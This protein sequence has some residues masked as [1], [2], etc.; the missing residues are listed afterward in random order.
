[1]NKED[2]DL[3]FA[4]NINFVRAADEAVRR[5]EKGLPSDRW[6]DGHAGQVRAV[7]GIKVYRRM[8]ELFAE[9]WTA[10]DEMDRQRGLDSMEATP[11]PMRDG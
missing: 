3:F 4:K 2:I 5:M 6:F 7:R 1:M 10:R 11:D 8:A 9:A